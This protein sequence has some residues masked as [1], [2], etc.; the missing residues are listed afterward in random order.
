[1]P[2]FVLQWESPQLDYY[3][4]HHLLHE[5]YAKNLVRDRLGDQEN[6]W[7]ASCDVHG[8]GFHLDRRE[9][10]RLAP[11]ARA[12]YAD[13]ERLM[14][15]FRDIEA[16]S[17]QVET[18][19]W[20]PTPGD[21]P[22]TEL[23]KIEPLFHEAIGLHLCSQPH[24]TAAVERELAEALDTLDLGDQERDEA[25]DWLLRPRRLPLVLQ[26]RLDWF[27]QV[28][29]APAEL[30][31][32][33]L[34]GHLGTWRCLTA[35]DSK[36]P[37]T[38]SEL[39][40]RLE[41][42]RRSADQTAEQ[43]QRLRDIADGRVPPMPSPLR[44]P[45]SVMEWAERARELAYHR[46]MTKQTW[47]KLWYL[48]E[49]YRVL[50]GPQSAGLITQEVDQEPLEDEDRSCYVLLSTGGFVELYYNGTDEATRERHLSPLQPLGDR[51]LS[52]STGYPGLVEG[53]VVVIDWN[54]SLENKSH[55]VDANTVLVV[56]QTTPDFVPVL[57]RCAGLVV[58]EGGL[59]GHASII[60]REMRLP[61]LIGS[62]VGTKLLRDGDRVLLNAS[63]GWVRIT[64]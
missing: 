55:L 19:P 22:I 28:L 20:H 49:Q 31:E 13:R 64:H 6:D 39:R 27:E 24:L 48:M 32:Q 2:D 11:L 29:T 26:E 3:W 59:T 14:A 38:E 34:Q 16:L 61:A 45:Q 30:T 17:R 62:R 58:D 25:L 35:G 42:D 40:A 1:M 8:F 18:L 36:Q 7:I 57:S 47:L 9:I 60:A 54:E 50:L 5:V 43:A 4:C 10:D 37:T 12:F 53:I 56:P 51:P 33:R 52:G 23:N 44:G 63:E 15:Y 41:A 46:F 21:D